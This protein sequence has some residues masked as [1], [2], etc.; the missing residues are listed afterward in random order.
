VA[1]LPTIAGNLFNIINSTDG[2]RDWDP[3]KGV[4]WFVP[5]G[6]LTDVSWKN[7]WKWGNNG[8]NGTYGFPIIPREPWVICFMTIPTVVANGVN[9]DASFVY[10]VMGYFNYELH[11]VSQWVPQFL[12]NVDYETVRGLVRLF[13]GQDINY[14]MDN[15]LHW[16]DIKNFIKRTAGIVSKVLSFAPAVASVFPVAAGSLPFTS[17]AGKIASAIEGAL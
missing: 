2:A 7:L 11:N 8:V 17:A 3:A 12:A 5:F 4:F 6:D 1:G 15:P 16:E 10:T 13:S 14:A 9:S